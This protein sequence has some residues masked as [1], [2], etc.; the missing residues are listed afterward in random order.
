M[1]GRWESNINVWFPFMYSE[2]WNCCFQNRIIKSCLPVPKLIYLWEIYIF[3]GS[4]CLFCCREICGPILG[5]Y[6][7][8]TTHECGCGKWEWG[9]AIPRKG[10]NKWDFPCSVVWWNRNRFWRTVF[11]NE[12][13]KSI[14]PQY[15]YE[16]NIDWARLSWP[17]LEW[18][19]WVYTVW[20]VWMIMNS[21]AVSI[22]SMASVNGY[23]YWGCEHGDWRV[24]PVTGVSMMSMNNV[25]DYE[26]WVCQQD[27]Y[28]QCEWF[29]AVSLW[30]C[31][32]WRVLPLR[33]WAWWVWTVWMIMN[34][35][36]VSMEIGEYG[37]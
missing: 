34:S 8:L 30:A 23:E 19:L 3:P 25:N 18:A 26:Q 35:E 11:I 24:W 33:V 36:G 14:S 31:G 6:K 2:K 9:W 4:V 10:I 7:S 13:K 16:L 21:V 1:K 17:L 22:V 28:E 5:I 27:E 29:W 20:T 37:Q 12:W 15:E 32:D